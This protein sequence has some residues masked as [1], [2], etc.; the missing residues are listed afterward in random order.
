M[1][2]AYFW[3]YKF[4]YYRIDLNAA[5]KQFEDDNAKIFIGGKGDPDFWSNF[6]KEVSAQVDIFIDD[7]GH[8]INQQ[9]V[10]FDEMF[11]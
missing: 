11:W 3:K 1:W 5:T 6:K 10:T 4:K 7:A 2:Q 9:L 8:R